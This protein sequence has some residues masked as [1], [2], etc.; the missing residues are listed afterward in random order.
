RLADVAHARPRTEDKIM[1][2]ILER[3][4]GGIECQLDAVHG[5]ARLRF[6]IVRHVLQDLLA[7]VRVIVIDRQCGRAC[8][9]ED[10]SALDLDAGYERHED[11]AVIVRMM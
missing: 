4:A 10:L 6:E 1:H 11:A 8:K 9:P 2:N 7:L 3:S 5:G